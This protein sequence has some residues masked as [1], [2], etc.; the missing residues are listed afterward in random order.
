MNQGKTHFADDDTL[1]H[2]ANLEA[3]LLNYQEISRQLVDQAAA[4]TQERD[5]LKLAYAECSRQ[6]NELL[7]SHKKLSAAQA[8]IKVLLD[9]LDTW[10]THTS[11]EDCPVCTALS[12]IDDSTALDEMLKKERETPTSKTTEVGGAKTVI[13]QQGCGHGAPLFV[14]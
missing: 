5:E 12:Q 2:I 9:L 14:L 6:R 8:R 7:N 4:L 11:D 10:G 3:K 1:R 13:S